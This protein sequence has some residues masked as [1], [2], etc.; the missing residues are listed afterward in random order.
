MKFKS[1]KICEKCAKKG[2]KVYLRV[3]RKT[4]SITVKVCPKCN[5]RVIISR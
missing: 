1:K 3:V 5:K 4:V 2:E